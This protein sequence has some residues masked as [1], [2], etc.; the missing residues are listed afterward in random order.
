LD[1]GGEERPSNR[2]IGVPAEGA[3]EEKE[4]GEVGRDEPFLRQDEL[5]RAPTMT[6]SDR[7]VGRRSGR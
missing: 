7:G 4:A 6:W 2:E 1:S 5:K 3:A